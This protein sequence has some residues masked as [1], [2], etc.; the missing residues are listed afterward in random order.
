MLVFDRMHVIDVF[1]ELGN[2]RSVPVNNLPMLALLQA[3]CMLVDLGLDPYSIDK[4]IAGF[5]M[6]MGPFRY[7]MWQAPLNF[8]Y[9]PFNSDSSSCTSAQRRVEG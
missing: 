6:P 5:G 7:V 8:W 2:P 4:V 3:A 9:H 1:P